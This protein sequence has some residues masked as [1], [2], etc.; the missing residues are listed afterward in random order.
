MRF[1]SRYLDVRKFE[2]KLLRE[3]GNRNHNK[4][5]EGNR[6]EV[7]KFVLEADPKRYDRLTRIHLESTNYR[8]ID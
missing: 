3:V 1:H 8:I 7:V 2:F 5:F 6:E 4:R